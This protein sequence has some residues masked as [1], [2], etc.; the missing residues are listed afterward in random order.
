MAQTTA[1][2]GASAGR[3]AVAPVR[4]EESTT[5]P[6]TTTAPST[7]DIKSMAGVQ[8]PVGY[9]DPIGV[10]DDA[11]PEVVYWL[12]AAE[13]KHGRVCMLAMTGWL[14]NTGGTF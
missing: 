11:A 12:R 8:N 7:V 9:F 13:L 1:F 4:A 14:I 10:C 5:V 3:S 2:A 6:S